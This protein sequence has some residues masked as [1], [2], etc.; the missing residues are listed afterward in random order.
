M[1]ISDII[2]PASIAVQVDIATKEQALKLAAE[3]LGKQSNLNPIR[4]REALAA[5]EALGSTG[6]GRGIAVPHVS[7]PGLDRSYAFFCTVAHPID[8]GS[9]DNEPVDLICT[10]ISPE[11]TKSG[12][13]QSLT[14]LAAITRILRDDAK[15]SGFRNAKNPTE[16]YDIIVKSTEAS[17]KLLS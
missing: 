10:I 8:F 3:N 5:R 6:I 13:S 1:R 14:Y 16:V 2:T 15:A 17:C 4:I 12:T 11:N 9:I 7:F